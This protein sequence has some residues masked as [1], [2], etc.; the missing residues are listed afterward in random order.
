MRGLGGRGAAGKADSSGWARCGSLM[1]GA[2]PDSHLHSD[3]I[4]IRAVQRC[5]DPELASAQNSYVSSES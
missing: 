3:S 1:E 4:Y 5:R 2:V